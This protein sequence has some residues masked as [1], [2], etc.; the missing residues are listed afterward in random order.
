WG[1]RS[2]TA[3]NGVE[4]LDEL[5]GALNAGEPY[6]LALID[7]SLPGMEK[8]ELAL[9]IGSD[10]NLA[11]LGMVLLTSLGSTRH[12]WDDTA[13]LFDASLTKPVRQRELQ[14][15]L[16]RLLS[17][18][19]DRGIPRE[20]DTRLEEA[21][22]GR[23]GRILVAEDNS[24][25][26][27]VLLHILESLGQSGV[28]AASGKEVLQELQS[29]P[30]D[31]V[32]MDLHMP[33]MD[34]I[35]AT[36]RIRT[37]P[38]GVGRRNAAL[39]I[40][41]MSGHTGQDTTCLQAGMND[42]LHKPVEPAAVAETLR[43]WLPSRSG[44]SGTGFPGERPKGLPESGDATEP[45]AAAPS[46]W[47]Q[48]TFLD[49]VLGNREAADEVVRLTLQELPGKMEGLRKAL[50]Q[51]NAPEAEQWAH[52]AR[53]IASN[54]GADA[55]YQTLSTIETAAGRRTVEPARS[56][57]REV[58]RQYELLLSELRRGLGERD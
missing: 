15:V 43:Q 40:I 5:T 22:A 21:L 44:Q 14:Q 6:R 37:L 10:P 29:S 50:E 27:K 1:M 18:E 12:N 3:A 52:A 19:K 53:G 57:R 23:R 46:T 8:G 20:E 41:A 26:Q 48:K 13:E 35:E 51:G 9:A 24:T 34:G 47:D 11:K 30:Y 17:G 2:T 55:L 25:N 28:A 16:L 45:P 32:F 38:T 36:R 58:E 56:L 7:S 54:I 49:R 33:G 31:L 42:V 4:A 39:P